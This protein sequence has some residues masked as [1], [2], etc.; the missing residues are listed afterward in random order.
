[1][2]RVDEM[3]RLT[4]IVNVLKSG[5]ASRKEIEEYLDRKSE[6]TGLDLRVSERTFA[7]DKLA[8]QTIFDMQI[9]YDFSNKKHFIQQSDQDDQL[10]NRTLEAFEIYNTL[11]LSTGMADF[12]SFEETKSL[13]LENFHGLLHAIKNRCQ[14]NFRYQS[15]WQEDPS[16]KKTHPY[17]LKEFKKRW[18][19]IAKD[20]KDETLKTFALDRLGEIDITKKKFKYPV[21]LNPNE[22][23]KN[24][25]GII[26]SLDHLEPEKVV[27]SFSKEQGN[28]VK[29][30]PLHHSQEILVDNDHEL[31]IQLTV[32]VVFD[33]LKELL[34]FGAN[35]KVIAPESLKIEI[36]EAHQKAFEQ[37]T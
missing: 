12:I 5:P 27:L 36:R 25:F 13:G 22:K 30:L 14:L 34:S 28:Y 10:G 21:N 11:N 17:L 8:I 7:R 4:A 3:T 19:L 35:M 26:S 15:F 6:L 24:S 29:T 37:Y 2:A 9:E 1:M 23:F 32:Y 33:F 20:L 31:R 16:S 18:Y